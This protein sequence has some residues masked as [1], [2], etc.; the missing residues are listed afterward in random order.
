MYCIFTNNN[1][2]VKTI[3]KF[4]PEFLAHTKGRTKQL[5]M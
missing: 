5:I 2:N 4:I 1:N 3:T